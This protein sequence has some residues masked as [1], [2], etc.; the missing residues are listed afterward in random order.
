VRLTVVCHCHIEDHNDAEHISARGVIARDGKLQVLDDDGKI[1][2]WSTLMRCHKPAVLIATESE[3]NVW[4]E[5]EKKTN[6]GRENR[7][8]H[9]ERSPLTAQ[10]C[11]TRE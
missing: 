11:D 10:S 7:D 8:A 1:H 9:E 5:H 4:E 6:N 2:R 3:F